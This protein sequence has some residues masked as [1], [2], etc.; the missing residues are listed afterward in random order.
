MC[1]EE[2]PT[3]TRGGV[4]SSAHLPLGSLGVQ[5]EVKAAAEAKEVDLLVQWEGAKKEAE[6]AYRELTKSRVAMSEA[7]AVSQSENHLTSQVG[8]LPAHYIII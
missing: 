3:L 2:L 7:E 1:C 5:M 8:S 4:L 6:L